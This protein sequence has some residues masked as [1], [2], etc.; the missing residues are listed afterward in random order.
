MAM[1]CLRWDWVHQAD[2]LLGAALGAFALGL[3]DGYVFRYWR[4]NW[5]VRWSIIVGLSQGGSR[6][7]LRRLHGLTLSTVLLHSSVRCGA[8]LAIGCLCWD[9]VLQTDALLGGAR[10]AS[11]GLI[12]WCVLRYWWCNWLVPWCI[13]VL[14]H[15]LRRLHGS[16]CPRYCCSPE[17]IMV[18]G[19]L[20]V[21]CVGT[22]FIMQL[23]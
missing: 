17:F 10:V 14:P 12:R 13:C 9:W 20:C 23:R 16:H 7:G 1:G 21:A 15:L 22:R 11:A 18:R 2:T 5:L 8:M 4:C 6:H 3:S 19:W